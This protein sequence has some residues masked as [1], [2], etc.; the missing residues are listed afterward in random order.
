MHQRIDPAWLLVTTSALALALGALGCGPG[1]HSDDG[2]GGG[3]DV[4]TD[5]A[6]AGDSALDAF[7][8]DAADA[9]ATDAADAA[10]GDTAPFATVPHTL[11]PQ[12]VLGAASGEVTTPRIVSVLAANDDLA[13]ELAAFGD[14]AIHSAWWREMARDYGVGAARAH[15]RVDGPAIPS[16]TLTQAEMVTYVQNAVRAA[17]TPPVA[18]GHTIYVLYLPAGVSNTSAASTPTCVES[19]HRA[20]PGGT[21]GMGDGI[22]IVGRCAPRTGQTQLEQITTTSSHEIAE[23]AT[24]TADGWALARLDTDPAWMYSIWIE[25]EGG[26]HTEIGDICSL[27]TRI[28]E[29]GFVYQRV[30][31]NSAAA[32]GGDPCVPFHP[33]PYYSVSTP[34]GW[35]AAPARPAS[36][37]WTVTIPVTGWST[38]ATDDWLISSA[39]PY[40]S[41][42]GVTAQSALASDTMTMLGGMTYHTINNGRTATLTVTLPAAAASGDWFALF[43]RSFR[44][45][46]SGDP[47]PN[48][49][50]AH[51][52]M[53]G[54]YVP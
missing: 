38:A 41:R 42:T 26:A 17:P 34:N 33:F 22:A 47:L 44:R 4:A 49:D 10:A 35:Y 25:E 31:S 20:F 29:G 23:A 21:T 16:G 39:V 12:V 3:P 40:S 7:A 30:F 27:E 5:S 32:A 37:A 53:V 11:Y 43:V 19:Y 1:A 6:S 50:F 45:D 51:R 48:D 2:G 13:T 24:D 54:V 9:L 52:W 46:A 18:D 28:R 8:T 36:A 14:A 15:V